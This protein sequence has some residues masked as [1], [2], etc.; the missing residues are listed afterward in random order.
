MK[1][2]VL[3]KK[4]ELEDICRKTHLIHESD[5]SIDF[6]IEAVESGKSYVSERY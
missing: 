4:G 1:E 6:A 3:K 2:L 5:G